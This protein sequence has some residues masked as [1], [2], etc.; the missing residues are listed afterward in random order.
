V[1]RNLKGFFFYVLCYSFVLQPACV[2]GYVQELLN[3]TKTWGT[4]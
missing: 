3:R 1:R 2:I 4:K